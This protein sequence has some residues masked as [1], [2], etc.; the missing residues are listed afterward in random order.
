MPDGQNG[1]A[2]A[3]RRPRADAQRNRQRLL[4]VAGD[5]FAAADSDAEVSLEAIARTA[6]VGIGTLYRHF[7]TRQDLVEAVYRNELDD[8]V[9]SAP[10][11]LT[12]APAADALRSWA[13]RYAAFV[14]TKRGMADTL[15]HVW[16][17]G[18][19]T[20][21]DTRVRVRSAVAEFL[22]AGAEDGTLRTDVKADD[23]VATLLGVFL[24][25]ANTPDGSQ[26]GRMLDLVLGGLR[27]R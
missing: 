4:S 24:A 6:E 2:G 19:L 22:R 3:A 10:L 20:P 8:V 16:S 1:P 21:S 7:P 11:F 25:T 15:Q 13:D 17:A 5:A 27:P 23:V 12:E 18:A 26:V 9:A 14:A